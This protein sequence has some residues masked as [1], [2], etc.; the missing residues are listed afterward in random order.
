MTNKTKAPAGCCPARGCRC[1]CVCIQEDYNFSLK[2]RQLVEKLE[3]YER[4]FREVRKRHMYDLLMA[5]ARIPDDPSLLALLD[6]LELIDMDDKVFKQW[7][8]VYDG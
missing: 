4:A 6:L 7:E 1:A 2:E 3:K 5:Q 8:A